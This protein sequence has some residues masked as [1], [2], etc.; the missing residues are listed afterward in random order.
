MWPRS[1]RHRRILTAFA[2]VGPSEDALQGALGLFDGHQ[3]GSMPLRLQ[4]LQQT[5]ML[6]I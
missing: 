6:N 3:G 5:N 4:H 1:P 2:V